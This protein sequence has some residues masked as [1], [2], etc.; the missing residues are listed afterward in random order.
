M[1]G[2]FCRENKDKLIGCSGEGRPTCKAPEC[3]YG[4]E[5]CPNPEC[6]GWKAEGETCG[7]CGYPYDKLIDAFRSLDSAVKVD[8]RKPN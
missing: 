4:A 8:E 2:K 1:I 6:N 7:W 3:V 5:P